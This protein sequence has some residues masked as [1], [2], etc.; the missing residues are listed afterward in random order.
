MRQKELENRLQLFARRLVKLPEGHVLHLSKMQMDE[1]FARYQVQVIDTA[2]SGEACSFPRNYHMRSR[3]FGP[4][5][6][7]FMEALEAVADGKLT[8]RR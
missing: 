5:L 8:V 4:Y 7:G 3:E 1:E 6:E 2:T